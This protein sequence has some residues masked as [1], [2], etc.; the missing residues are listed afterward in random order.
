MAQ[1]D[2]S[3]EEKASEEKTVTQKA[4][5]LLTRREYSRNELYTRLCKMADEEIVDTVLQKLANDGLQSDE[6]FT[7]MLCRA[8]YNAGK[9]PVFI[10]H[11]LDQ[12]GIDAHIIEASLTPYENEWSKLAYE[13]RIK[14][15]G[16]KPATDYASWAKQAR[17]LQQR[18]FT[19]EHFGYFDSTVDD[20]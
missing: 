10:R 1:Q 18:G 7:Q 3:S 17:F 11:E 16:Q 5:S 15:F 13:V 9:G 12:H 20:I 6:R 2:Q 14:K 4:I 19:P 8:R